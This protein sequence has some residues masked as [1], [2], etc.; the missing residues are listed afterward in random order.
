[1]LKILKNHDFRHI[2]F[3]RLISNCGDSIYTI[4]LSW[5]V[6]STTHNS[7]WVGFLD[8]LIFIPN[9]FAFLFGKIIDATNKKKLLVLLE[10][11]QGTAVFG[12]IIA[13]LI[14]NKIITLPLIFLCVFLASTAGLNTYTVQDSLIPKIVPRFQLPQ[15]EMYMSVAY[16]GSDYVF[17]A[18]TGFLINILSYPILMTIDL[19][20]FIISALSFSSVRYDHDKPFFEKDVSFH[21]H[22]VQYFKDGMHLI[23]QSSVI[24]ALCIGDSLINFLFGGLNVYELLIAKSIGGAPFYGLMTAASS[25]GLL[26]GATVVSNL[27]LKKF[28]LGEIYCVSHLIYGLGVM[29]IIFTTSSK[30][31]T[32]IGW[33]VAF[34]FLGIGQTMC[35]PI[36]QTELPQKQMGEA[37]SFY[38]TITVTTLP[39][40]S[41]LFGYIAKFINWKYFII[42][43]GVVN[44]VM[45]VGFLFNK[46][47]VKYSV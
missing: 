8:F 47:L 6:L 35:K 39:L 24:I 42:L 7:F 29:I 12:I 44:I 27:L 11:I 41:L 10:M 5:Y 14:N 33:G 20:S 45:A 30:V 34:A 17:N 26:L 13:M 18:I 36:L 25:I 43:F 1:M 15:S 9:V 38:Y 37:L 2:F 23:S 3:G 46:R 22:P 4:A 31:A 32:L 28:K 19:V 21:F 40:G 16:N